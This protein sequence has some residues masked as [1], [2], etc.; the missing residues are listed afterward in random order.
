MNAL[1]NRQAVRR[2][3]GFL[4]YSLGNEEV[5][6]AVAP[7]LGARILSLKNLRTG[8]EW[9]WHPG[10]SLKL[11]RN[12]VGDDFSRSPLAGID[13]CFPTIASCQWRGR[14]LPDH[15][16][17]WNADWLVDDVAWQNGVLTTRVHSHLS[18]FQFERTVQLDDNE[19]QLHYQIT[20][21]SDTEEK[22]IWALHPL[23][24]LQPGDR[25]RLP[26][27]SRKQ[28][29]GA[30]WIDGIGDNVSGKMCA[31]AFAR[32]V[33]EGWAAI[34]NSATGD[35]LEFSWNPEDNPVLG[36]WL[37]RGGWHGH[38][39][40]AI[41]PANGDHD[42]LATAAAQNRCGTIDAR[43]IISWKICLRLKSCP[44]A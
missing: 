30:A 41:E 17:L 42:S 44:C 14:Q 32:S 35:A 33:R 37:T 3:Q 21:L 1:V 9:L 22:F 39:H 8:R 11:F 18:P 6:V 16:E 31:K 19:V 43:G 4:L 29:N 25:L 15:G 10:G 24:R 38:H 20:N 5:A 13:E 7:E 23:L 2:E 26:E 40:F 28:F 34:H 36:L 27:S 12:S